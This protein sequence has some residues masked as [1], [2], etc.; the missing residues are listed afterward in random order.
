MVR[1]Q[2]YEQFVT[3][4][5]ERRWKGPW[6]DFELTPPTKKPKKRPHKQVSTGRSSLT[7]DQAGGRGP[8][9]FAA[10]SGGADRAAPHSGVKGPPYSLDERVIRLD[11]SAQLEYGHGQVSVAPGGLSAR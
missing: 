11:R 1:L 5:H 2:D 4:H 7:L 8:G 6:L 10:L 3:K 9:T